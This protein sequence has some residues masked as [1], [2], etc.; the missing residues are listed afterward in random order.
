MRDA[1]RITVT[2]RDRVSVSPNTAFVS[3]QQAPGEDEMRRDVIQS[4]CLFVYFS[5]SAQA[6]Q[7]WITEHPGT[8]VAPLED[9]LEFGRKEIQA[10]LVYGRLG[11]DPVWVHSVNI[12]DAGQ[13]V[14]Q[15]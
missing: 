3:L 11:G 15:L 5:S 9:A 14:D 12:F 8:F 1:I 10:N 7:G 2:S 13:H 6:G 4:F